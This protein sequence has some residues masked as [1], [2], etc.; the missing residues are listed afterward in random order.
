MN[1]YKKLSE[2]YDIIFPLNQQSITFI[3][4]RIDHGKI[5]DLAAGTGNHTIA[6][7]KLGFTVSATDLDENMVKM[8]SEKADQER[9]NVEVAQLAMEHL[10]ELKENEF[11]TIIC[12]GNSL[13]H[14][15]TLEA[16]ENT[17]MNMKQLL[18]KGG[19]IIIQIVNFDRIL[20]QGITELPL[21]NRNAEQITFSRTYQYVEDKITFKGKLLVDD[22]VFEQEVSLLPLTSIQLQE[23]LTNVGFHSINL[24]G[25]FKG[26]GFSLDSPALIIEAVK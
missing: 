22:E 17:L 10:Y 16:V 26:E 18:Q 5:L 6:L 25:S 11:S 24:Y 19:K 4:E 1:F 7:A 23:L 14:L 12:L 2:Y 15:E 13:V 3:K 21:I 20:T 8:I 9:V